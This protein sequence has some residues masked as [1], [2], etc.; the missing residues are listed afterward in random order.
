VLSQCLQNLLSNALKYGS[1]G[2]RI[3]L[4]ANEARDDGQAQVQIAVQDFG[5]GIAPEE[6]AHIYEPFYRTTAARESQIHGTGLGL[7]L[8]RNMIE[9]L[10]GRITVQSSPGKGSIFTLHVPA[11]IRNSSAEAASESSHSG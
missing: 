8:T 4:T 10:D 9:G 11:S 2:Q 7:S 3:V 6:L 5:A 1:S